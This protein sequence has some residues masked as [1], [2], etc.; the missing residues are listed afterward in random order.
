MSV[1]LPY[2]ENGECRRR[3]FL[4]K[5]G[6]EFQ[7]KPESVSMLMEFEMMNKDNGMMDKIATVKETWLDC[8][9]RCYMDVRC[10]GFKSYTHSSG[11]LCELYDYFPLPSDSV[12]V[13]G[14]Y[15]LHC[16]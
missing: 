14:Y 1:L 5:P 3:V 10:H 4:F 9:R 15:Q 11:D 13:G 2:V 8:S 16:V 6:P 7:C 12:V